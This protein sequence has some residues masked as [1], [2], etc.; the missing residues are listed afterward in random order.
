MSLNVPCHLES[1]V[2][3]CVHR[4]SPNFQTYAVSLHQL[5]KEHRAMIISFYYHTMMSITVCLALCTAKDSV[6]LVVVHKM[7]C[8]CLKG[9]NI[10]LTH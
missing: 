9:N 10:L 3:V 8:V 2:P 4:K 7:K 6:T 5:L 1:L